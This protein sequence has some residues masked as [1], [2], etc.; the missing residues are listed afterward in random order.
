M[1]PHKGSTLAHSSRSPQVLRDAE[2]IVVFPVQKGESR[3][4]RDG[5]RTS[6]LQPGRL[7]CHSLH[8]RFAPL[9]SLLPAGIAH[10]D[11]HGLS[12]PDHVV[13][14]SSGN[15]TEK[16]VFL[17]FPLCFCQPNREICVL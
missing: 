9:S 8:C 17:K 4:D 1:A 7:A 15:F 14:E 10:T 6:W 11:E 5:A 2:P 12:V 16:S 3:P 13:G